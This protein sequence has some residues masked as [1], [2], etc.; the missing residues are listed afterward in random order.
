MHWAIRSVSKWFGEVVPNRVAQQ[1]DSNGCM[2]CLTLWRT[3][4]QN[5]CINFMDKNASKL[6]SKFRKERRIEEE[7]E[8]KSYRKDKDNNK[9]VCVWVATFFCP[10]P[11]NLWAACNIILLWVFFF[12]FFFLLNQLP[13]RKCQAR[14]GGPRKI[15]YKIF[16][17]YLFSIFPCGLLWLPPSFSSWTIASSACIAA[18]HCSE[19]S[20]PPTSALGK[21]T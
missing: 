18:L 2:H 8:K 15:C 21:I 11:A 13:P 4:T 5:V 20:P 17:S 6:R 19:N 10:C 7:R 9:V 1:G 3:H 12:I 14:E 16:S